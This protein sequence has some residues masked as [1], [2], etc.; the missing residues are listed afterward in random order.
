M[1]NY[2]DIVLFKMNVLSA[3]PDEYTHIVQ[4]YNK[5][6]IVPDNMLYQKYEPLIRASAKRLYRYS[7]GLGLELND[8][9]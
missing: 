2:D 9:I 6:T 5:K 1:N 8:Y 4:L 7:N 3:L